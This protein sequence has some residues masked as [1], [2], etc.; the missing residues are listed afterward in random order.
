MIHKW[1]AGDRVT[2]ELY[3]DDGTWEK[4]GDKCLP[5]SPLRHGLVTRRDAMWSD[6]IWV[7]WDDATN[8]RMYLDHGVDEEVA[9]AAPAA[10]S[11][12]TGPTDTTNPSL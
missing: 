10:V 3:L 5:Q 4:L 7:L 8:E 2:R 1:Q 12:A 11:V 6:G 9:G